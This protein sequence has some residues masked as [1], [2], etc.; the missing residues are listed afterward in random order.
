MKNLNL[1]SVGITDNVTAY[2]VPWVYYG[3]RALPGH[4]LRSDR[5]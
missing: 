2:N 1:S 3:A 4:C 5:I